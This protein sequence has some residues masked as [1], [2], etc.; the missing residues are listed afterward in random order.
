[1]V[2]DDLA[3]HALRTCPR[4]TEKRGVGNS[5][6]PVRFA[7]ATIEPGDWIAADTDGVIVAR[8]PLL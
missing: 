5:D 2:G 1:V 3:V 4:K 8:W 7:G 6:I